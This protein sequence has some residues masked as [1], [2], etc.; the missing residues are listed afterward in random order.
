M[1]N[2]I[3]AIATIIVFFVVGVFCLFRAREMQNYAVQ[4][5]KRNPD[6]ARWVPFLRYIKSPTYVTVTR[7]GGILTIGVALLLVFVLLWVR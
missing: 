4:Y 1:K 6:E 3:A 2:S 5:Y 7:I